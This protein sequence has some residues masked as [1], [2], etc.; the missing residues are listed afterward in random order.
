MAVEIPHEVVQFLNFAGVPYPDIDEDQVRELAGHVRTFA[1]EV[2]GTHEA[3][4][5]AI[6]EMGSVY[7]GR[8]YRALVASWGRM[9]ASHM[10]TLED[11]CQVV[12]T[13]LEVAADVITAVK[14]AVLT[15]LTL[16]AAAYTAAMAATVATAG[17]SAALGQSLALAAKRLV[18]AM[19]QALVAYILAEVLGRAIEPLEQAVADMVAGVVYDTV[20]DAL[21]TDGDDDALLIDP[22]EVRRYAQVLDDHADDIAGHAEKF[23]NRVSRLDF[24]TPVAPPPA[25]ADSGTGPQRPEPVGSPGRPAQSAESA[26]KPRNWLVDT[27]AGV[28]DVVPPRASSP[29]DS[30]S[31]PAGNVADPAAVPQGPGAPAETVSAAVGPESA[32]PGLESRGAGLEPGSAGPDS[33]GAGAD[34]GAAGRGV[35]AVDRVS[36]ARTGESPVMDEQPS[37]SGAEAAGIPDPAIDTAPV[38]RAQVETATDSAVPSAG[39]SRA[40]PDSP[41]GSEPRNQGGAATAGQNATATGPW[42]RAQTAAAPGRPVGTRAPAGGALPGDAGVKAGRRRESAAAGK[43]SPWRERPA[44]EPKPVPTPWAR[45]DTAPALPVVAAR[46]ETAL[47]PPVPVSRPEPENGVA[48]E[49]AAGTRRGSP[50]VPGRGSGALPAPDGVSV[51]PSPREESRRA[52][53]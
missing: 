35:A 8:S 17:S 18:T 12:V 33:L 21:G 13:A 30:G 10:E 50:V 3:A 6:T 20:A 43:P 27:G 36:Q 37:V 2:A 14:I 38:S 9:S 4:T 51:S 15:E 31:V 29:G 47:P 39:V 28:K 40:D 48:S 19:E 26:V 46:G 22:E 5:G 52:E 44:A 16:L 23:A 42:S 1:D 25:T 45:P 11:L 32:K 49:S 7:Q 24:T 41:A 53:G 34:A